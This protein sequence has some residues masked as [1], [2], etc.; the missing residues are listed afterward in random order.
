MG[1]V[2]IA[3]AF[4]ASCFGQYSPS[5]PLLGGGNTQTFSF[6]GLG[7]ILP[8]ATVPF[9]AAI[10]VGSSGNV[11]LYTVPAGRSMVCQSSAVVANPTAGSITIQPFIKSGGNYYLTGVTAAVGA[12]TTA[13]AAAMGTNVIFNSGESFSVN[14]TASGYS[15][16]IACQEYDAT[17]PLKR[18]ALVVPSAGDNTIYTAAVGKKTTALA[19]VISNSSGS[20][21]TLSTFFVPSGGGSGAGNRTRQ[22]TTANSGNVSTGIINP[23]GNFMPMNAGDFVVVNDDLATATQVIWLVYL[24]Q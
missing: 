6:G 21:R 3:L 16:W 7:M 1:K 14:G 20:T 17:G 24:E 18:S 11:D 4:C 22:A 5:S 8:N 15:V 13:F 12:N 23:G 9:V 2:I 19:I 10:N